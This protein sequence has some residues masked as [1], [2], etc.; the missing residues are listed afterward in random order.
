MPM[1]EVDWTTY[2]DSK[3]SFCSD[4][5]KSSKLEKLHHRK[6]PLEMCGKNK[7]YSHSVSFVT[8]SECLIDTNI[9]ILEAAAMAVARNDERKE[10]ETVFFFVIHRKLTF[11]YISSI[12][13]RVGNGTLYS[14]GQELFYK[15]ISNFTNKLVKQLLSMTVF[16]KVNN[17]SPVSEHFNPKLVKP[18]CV[19]DPLQCPKCK[20][21]FSKTNMDTFECLILEKKLILPL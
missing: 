9:A 8:Q 13:N 16:P 15:F 11:D 7:P 6:F 12:W 19:Q 4:Q 5:R 21:S 2:Y 10:K 20:E 3:S 17:C 14:N 1:S 18:N